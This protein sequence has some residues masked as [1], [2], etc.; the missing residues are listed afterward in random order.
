MGITTHHW[1][2][3]GRQAIDHRTWSATIL[4]I[5]YP[6]SCTSVKSMSHH[7][8]DKDV[9]CDSI[10]YL[11]QVQ[12]EYISCS[13]LTHQWPSA[14]EAG[15]IMTATQRGKVIA[16]YFGKIVLLCQP[17]QSSQI[18][19]I[20]S[21]L[22]FL[23]GRHLLLEEGHT[24]RPIRSFLDLFGLE[25]LGT[26]T[27]LWKKWKDLSRSCGHTGHLYWLFGEHN[28]FPIISGEKCFTLVLFQSLR[29][30]QSFQDGPL[31][32]MC[33]SVMSLT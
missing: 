4:P 24:T 23:K 26:F 32:Q 16:S 13:S 1:S 12:V 33:H 30:W 20:Q 11:A 5:P 2:L 15:S 21:F 28:C 10:K 14:R 17:H 7:F 31:M 8:R 22:H 18:Y 25:G 29:E 27:V 19:L 9:M 6:L 3:P